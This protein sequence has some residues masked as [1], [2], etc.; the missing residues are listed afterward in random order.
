VGRE[1]LAEVFGTFLLVVCGLS[2][3]AQHKFFLRENNWNFLPVNLA[4]GFGATI[5]VLTVG[6]V[7]G[8]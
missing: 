3:V 5:A 1:F 6:K 8:I 7:S 2:A 4:F